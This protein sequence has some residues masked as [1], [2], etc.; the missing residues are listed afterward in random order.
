MKIIIV[1]D[2]QAFRDIVYSIVHDIHGNPLEITRFENAVQ[3]WEDFLE[4]PADV[5]I[6]DVSMP[7]MSGLELLEKIKEMS[8]DT[9]V[10]VMSFQPY[11]K[12]EALRL[13][14]YTF[15]EKPFDLDKFTKT[16]HPLLKR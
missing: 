8:P 11:N 14:A 13:G 16:L 12:K 7:K 6:T 1:D 5:V 4:D 15:F 2:N 9:H 3:A 10:V